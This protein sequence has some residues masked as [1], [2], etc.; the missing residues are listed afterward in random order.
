VLSAVWPGLGQ[1]YLGDGR[2]AAILAIPPLIL[3]APLAIAAARGTTSLIGH[4]VVPGNAALLTA[5]VVISLV[6]RLISLALV[7]LQ[8]GAA[9]MK[10]YQLL[11]GFL[12]VL[13]LILHLAL[14]Y[15]SVGLFGV[16]SRV[17][18]GVILVPGDSPQ[19]GATQPLEVLP[20][21]AAPPAADQRV[22][23]LLVGSDSG[24]GY[25]HSLTDTMMVVSVDPKTSQVVMASVPRDT[26]QFQLYSGGIYRDK[27]NSL[28]SRASHDAKDYPDGGLGTLAKEIGY[29]VGIPID[30]VAYIDMGAFEKAIDAVG[31]VDVNV[32]RDIND[33]FYQFPNGPK[34][35]HLKKGPHHLDGPHA[36]AYVRSRY[37][38]GDNDFTR[39]RRQQEL[40][41]ALKA[42]LLDPGTLPRLP[43]LLDKISRLVTTNYPADH[44]EQLIDL[45][46][47]I[48]PDA[49][50]RFVLG[51]PYAIQPPGGGQYILV[52]NM[53]RIAKWSIAQFGPLSR[54]ATK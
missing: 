1:W 18:G 6:L 11:M 54:Y 53:D 35:F 39:A 43:D 5:F 40:L 49:I 9:A 17:F 23:F 30:Y 10:P 19:P 13:I 45:S 3:L 21:A 4:L 47:T 14:A 8:V 38:A 24:T 50:K 37:G 48:Q 46:R 44:I 34:G 22:T 16:T 25:A 15:A 32:T 33:N 27:L 51:P 28:M 29:L 20:S 2:T 42:K 41:V 36:V 52:P 31:G 26:A 7:R 12:V